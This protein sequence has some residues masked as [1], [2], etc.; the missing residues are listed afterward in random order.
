MNPDRWRQ[1]D[2]VFQ[3]VL[4]SD[5]DLRLSHLDQT[6]KGDPEL[7]D[8]VATLL[9]A[10][11]NAG[12]FIDVPAIKIAAKLEDPDPA[13]LAN[14]QSLGPYQVL[15]HL[16]SGG[17]GEVYLAQDTKLDRRV[18]LKVLR[19]DFSKD[20]G[21]IRRFKQEARSASALNH[22]N[23][24]TIYDIGSEQEIHYI[25]TEFVEGSTIRQRLTRGRIPVAEALGIAIQA[26]N[27]LQA[28]H[29]AGIVHRDI[30]PENIMVRPDG[31]VKVLDFGLAKLSEP[32]TG[33]NTSLAPSRSNLDTEP[34]IVMGTARYMSPEQARGLAVDGRTDIFSLGVV[35]YEMLT[36]VAPFE[37]ATPID[38]V[39]AMLGLDPDPLDQHVDGIPPGIEAVVLKALKK[40][41]EERYSSIE[42]FLAAL[43]SLR[44]ET[45]VERGLTGGH[46]LAANILSS[47]AE[48]GA[49]LLSST[50]ASAGSSRRPVVTPAATA[51]RSW[52]IVAT[53]GI[54][55]LIAA[56]GY[57]YLRADR[58]RPIDNNSPGPEPASLV[59][60]IAILPFV[61]TTGDKSVEYLS[62]GLTES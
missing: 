46:T 7:R 35:L 17:M 11:E 36:G 3:A 22:P 56:A 30:K 45:E 25:A 49:S 47:G 26:A 18:A 33:D 57:T 44:L 12:E 53:A 34:G 15:R 5:P 37:G 55:I 16:A 20:P 9:A 62:D 13:A 54:A 59:R 1:I 29:R 52:L 8:Q 39:A 10:H 32:S 61:D 41:R 51:Y 21:R 42:S 50:A 28:A 58:S 6:C 4:E 23:I 48:N 31:Y 24:I 60:S 38:A 27:A 2:S 40:D 14:L 43:N 19:T